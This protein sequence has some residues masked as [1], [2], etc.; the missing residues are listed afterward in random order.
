MEQQNNRQTKTL[1]W[2]IFYCS[3]L[4]RID[5]T[6]FLFENLEVYK[7]ITIMI[8]ELSAITELFPKGNYYL[9]G[10]PRYPG[11]YPDVLTIPRRFEN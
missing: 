10:Y 4:Q 5:N 3:I 8:D 2:F 7:K 9:S 11:Q 6:P 1:L